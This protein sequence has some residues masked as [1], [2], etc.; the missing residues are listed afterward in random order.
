MGFCA[1]RLMEC[2]RFMGFCAIR[3][4]ECTRFMGFCTIRLIETHFMGVLVS[5]GEVLVGSCGFW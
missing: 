3:L 5:S 4:I 2:T 1:I